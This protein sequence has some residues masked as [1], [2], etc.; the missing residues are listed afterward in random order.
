MAATMLTVMA[1]TF[2]EHDPIVTDEDEKAYLEKR[3]K[4]FEQLAT[5][6]FQYV[7]VQDESP[8]DAEE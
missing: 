7:D 3:E 4:I 8:M 6:G 1:Q 5:A 2:I